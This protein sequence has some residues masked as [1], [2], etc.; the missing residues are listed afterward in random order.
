[1]RRFVALA[2]AWLSATVVPGCSL[3]V[4]VGDLAHEDAG[5]AEVDGTADVDADVVVDVV[6]RAEADGPADVDADAGSDGDAGADADADADGDADADA[7]TDAD[8]DGE[9]DG[10]DGSSTCAGGW[11]DP[12]SGLCW[13][14]PP[15]D[16][17]RTW[18]DATAYCAGLSLG[19]YGPGSW[20]LPTIDELRSLIRG[21]PDAMT[22]DITTCNWSDGCPVCASCTRGEG[23]ASGCYWDPSLRGSCSYMSPYWSS[24]S[25][26]R[27]GG[28]AAAAVVSFDQGWVMY[29]A[30]GGGP[31]AVRCVRPGP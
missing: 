28:G 12:S 29:Q 16:T 11:L 6:D 26:T 22:G 7:D 17:L 19:G 3:I 31:W 25:C 5:T 2:V 13:Q 15:D 9:A 27:S 10:D 24:L 1:M 18:D 8:G 23:P 20:H 14:N 21:C 30:T 4:D